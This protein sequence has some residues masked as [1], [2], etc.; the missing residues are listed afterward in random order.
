VQLVIIAAGENKRLN[1]LTDGTPK[2]LLILKE[3]TILEY[4]I[5]NSI[6]SGIDH[7]I[8]ITGKFHNQI[9]KFV[10]NKHFQVKIDF[11]Y[12]SDWD[13]ENGISVLKSK[14]L[15]NKNSE[16]MI[17]MSDHFYDEELFSKI[18]LYKLK[19][20][21]A[22]V[23]IDF[24][25]QLIY[26]IDDAMKVKVDQKNNNKIKAMSKNLSKYN[27]VDCG[28]FKCNYKFFKVLEISKV[29]NKNNLSDS[30]NKLIAEKMMVGINIEESFWMDIDT[31]ESYK[32]LKS[33]NI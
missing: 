9:K 31:P 28:L 6:R 17:S 18:Y 24:K 20:H 32:K 8:I 11:I 14:P 16:F 15:I 26:D 22:S 23:G 3:K 25:L 21:I 4:I 1:S 5:E 30:C 10:S 12:N 33:Y 7:I 29:E 13:K 27:A 2:T 19:N